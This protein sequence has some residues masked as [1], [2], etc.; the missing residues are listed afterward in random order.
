MA[1]YSKIERRI[2]T[3]Q[4]FNSLSKDGKLIFFILLVHPHLTAI[5]AM[6]ATLAGLACEMKWP[7]E[8]FQTAFAELLQKNMV[9]Y[10]EEASLLWL[11][12][13][14]NH[15]Q[16]ESP[17]VVKSWGQ[18]LD[19]LS[20]C[21]LKTE[22][23]DYTKNFVEG[24]SESFREALPE[25]FLKATQY[26]EETLPESVTV[27]IAVTETVTGTGAEEYIV[28]KTRPREDETG[29]LK[30]I[31]N[32][33]KEIFRHPNA[34]LDEKRKK[35]IRNALRNGYS[36]TQLC[37]AITGC[38]YTPHNMGDNDR[39][40][41]YDGLHVILRDADQIDRFIHNAHNPPKPPNAAD[42][43]LEVNRRAAQNWLQQHQGE[44]VA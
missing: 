34:V 27:T 6:R 11:P 7:Y 43:L 42:K 10:D 1:R 37:Q 14:L 16:P 15:N 38:S 8:E 21:K 13:Y 3:D 4:K 22:I 32:H 26:F 5:G 33:W 36:E 30:I 9:K 29:S 18:C 17:N 25:A 24:L 41:R 19:Y 23:I 31:F 28:A 44:I 12:K 40:Q 20:E 2:L 35:L 39:G